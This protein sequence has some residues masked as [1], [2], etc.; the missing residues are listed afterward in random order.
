MN[1]N[2]VVLGCAAASTALV[3][4]ALIMVSIDYLGAHPLVVA[5]VGLSTLALATLRVKEV[6]P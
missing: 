4:G 3:P 6:L 2:R 1:Q 5:L